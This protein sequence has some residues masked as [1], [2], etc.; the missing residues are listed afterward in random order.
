VFFLFAAQFLMLD[1]P[2][3]WTGTAAD[4]GCRIDQNNPS[5]KAFLSLIII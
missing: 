1:E 3:F 5:Q 4:P 2:F